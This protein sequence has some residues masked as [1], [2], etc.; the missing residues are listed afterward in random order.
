MLLEMQSNEWALKPL[1]NARRTWEFPGS[2][3]LDPGTLM[4]VTNVL[5]T[6]KDE[7]NRW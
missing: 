6:L 5:Y 7:G 1:K 4:C 3:E 2:L